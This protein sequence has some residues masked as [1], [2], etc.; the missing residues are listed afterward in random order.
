M[1]VKTIQNISQYEEISRRLNASFAQSWQWGEIMITEGKEVERLV[2]KNDG[3]EVAVAQ[4]VYLPLVF[5]WWYAFCPKG[6]VGELSTEVLNMFGEHFKTKK[7]LFWRIELAQKIVYKNLKSSH[8]VNPRATLVLD[9][10][11]NEE[12]LLSAM[13]PK[14]RYNIRL[15]QK[16]N[17]EIKNEKNLKEF[18]E[19]MKKT[20]SRDNFRLHETKHYESILNSDLSR[21]LTVYSEQTP[22]AT[23]I[24]VG[25]GDTFTYLFGAS[26]HD[27]RQLMA[28]YLLQWEGIKMG[29]SESYKFYDFFGVAPACHSRESGNPID[30]NKDSHLHGNDNYEFDS[31]HQYAGV[32]RFKH[33]FGGMYHESPGTFDLVINNLKY[34]LYFYLRKLRRLI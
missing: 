15:A 7:V 9:L 16:K 14:T 20:G 12:E 11:K 2:V 27:Y 4:V 17:L 18:L 28:P 24:F 29:Q 26:D 23:A 1:Q 22:I 31:K 8:D 25:Y 30:D 19:L 33:G 6:P 5:G 13:H 34:K 3:E 10:Q 32:S 21:Q